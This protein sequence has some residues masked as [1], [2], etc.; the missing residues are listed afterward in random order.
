[1]CT[2]HANLGS[3]STSDFDLPS[4]SAEK[5]GLSYE[6]VVLRGLFLKKL[7][8]YINKAVEIIRKIITIFSNTMRRKLPLL[9]MFL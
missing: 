3:D 8:S 9:L 7:F 5:W 6:I 2:Q 1:M 4:L